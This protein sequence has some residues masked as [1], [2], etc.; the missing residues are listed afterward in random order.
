MCVENFVEVHVAERALDDF[1]RRL[2]CAHH[3]ADVL[4]FI[5]RDL[6]GLIEQDDVAEFNL[7]YDEVLDVLLVYVLAGQRFAAGE[8]IA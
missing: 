7:L 2:Q 4:E 1:S 8:F 5:G 6:V 3:A